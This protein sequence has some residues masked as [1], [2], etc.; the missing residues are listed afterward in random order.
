MRRLLV[1]LIVFS[2]FLSGCRTSLF[3]PMEPAME[4]E[5]LAFEQ[6]KVPGT[7][8][9]K[10]IAVVGLGDSLTE[11]I[12]D[13]LKM[14]GYFGRL[15][16]VMED[17]KGVES[18]QVDNL[19]KKGRRS[20]QLI[21]QLEDPKIQL[22]IRKADVV[23]LTIGGNDLMKIVKRDLF[24]LQEDRFYAELKNYEQ[25]LDEVFGIIRALNAD[26]VIIV[27]GLYNPLSILTNEASEF[28]GI[29]DG[30]N[31]VIELQTVLDRK[32]CFI[33][34]KD[35]FYSNENMVYHTDFFHPNAKG[36][37]QMTGRYIEEIDKCGL[38]NLSDGKLGM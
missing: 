11:G 31:D 24:N 18:V 28:E 16:T 29:I 3:V 21:K 12:G 1:V 4:R 15:T 6:W 10:R 20:D 30:W 19:A 7:F 38:Y 25:R 37:D 26:A 35:L 9:P 17:W 33:P 8:V 23:L 27:G 34:V 22:F 2:L 13:E 14:G 36:Y 32:A 5:S